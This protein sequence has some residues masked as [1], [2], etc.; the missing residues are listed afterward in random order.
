[1]NRYALIELSTGLVVNVAVWDGTTEWA[2]E[3]GVI[4]VASDEAQIGWI[5]AEGKFVAPL[6]PADP[7]PTPEEILATNSAVR[8]YLLG[9]AALAI[10]PLQDAVDLE[11]AT[12]EEVVLL[13]KWKQY[14]VAVN[15]IDLTLLAP[16]WPVSP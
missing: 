9:Q 13:K 6:T 14:R 10:A 8:D 7:P 1:M 12:A 16:E 4:A 11:E 5:Y 15:R 2:P 3:E